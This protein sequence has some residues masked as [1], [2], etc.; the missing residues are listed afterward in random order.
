M[1]W[2]IWIYICQILQEVPKSLFHPSN[3]LTTK[4]KKVLH[5]SFSKIW[6]AQI[7]NIVELKYVAFY[8]NNKVIEHTLSLAFWHEKVQQQKVLH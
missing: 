7:K 6:R 4:V 3:F 8:S 1:L 5:I 2:Y